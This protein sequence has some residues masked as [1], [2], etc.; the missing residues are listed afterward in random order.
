MKKIYKLQFQFSLFSLFF[1]TLMPA[2]TVA[3]YSFAQT[4]SSLTPL[5]GGSVLGNSTNDDDLFG[6]FAIGFSF[7]YHNTVYTNFSVNTNG[8]IVLGA[9]TTGSSTA[10][11]SDAMS[12]T[13]GSINN[14]IAGLSEDLIGQAGSV[15]SWQVQGSNTN[16][17]LVVEWKNY[18]MYGTDGFGSA[19]PGTNDALTFQI[20]LYQ[21]SNKIQVVYGTMN[22]DTLAHYNPEVG[23]RGNSNTDFNNRK[24]NASNTWATSVAGTV[25]N[26]VC[27]LNSV[28]HP[29]T[30]QAYTWTRTSVGVENIEAEAIS[31][32]D[33]YPNPASATVKLSVPDLHADHFTISIYNIEG[34]TVY[35]EKDTNVIGYFSKQIPTENLAKGIYYIKLDTDKGADVKKLVIQ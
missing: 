30:G 6:P 27:L 2:Q 35:S 34:K 8:Y 7:N 28:K 17:I 5:V 26:D 32:F 14:A 25:N 10:V 22:A 15:L 33:I 29:L 20:Q 23:L 9:A 3:V 18:N 11:L 4:S 19:V 31:L 16:H 21:T 24:V 13:N 12:N 1:I